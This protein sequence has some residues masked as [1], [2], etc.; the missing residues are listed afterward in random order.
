MYE[1]RDVKEEQGKKKD[2]SWVATSVLIGVII[3]VVMLTG[4]C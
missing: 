4:G 1:Y 2:K 3:V